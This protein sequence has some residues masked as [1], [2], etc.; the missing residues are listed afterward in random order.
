MKRS[1]N[2]FNRNTLWLVAATYIVLTTLF[3]RSEFREVFE[4]YLFDLRVSWSKDL[5][6]SDSVILVG[7]DEVT[8]SALEQSQKTP[9][10]DPGGLQLLSMES[11]ESIVRSIY[12][13]EAKAIVLLLPNHAFSHTDL[14]LLPIVN[15]IKNDPR[16]R[17]GTLEYHRPYQNVLRIP[18]PLNLVE[19][20]VFGFETFRNRS[21]IVVRDLPT[22]GFR[23]LSKKKMLPVEL[24]DALYPPKV[25]DWKTYRPYPIR[26]NRFAQISGANLLDGSMQPDQQGLSQLKD[27]I[28]I[29]GYSTNREIPFQTTEMNLVNTPHIGSQETV[30]YGI[31]LIY[32][33]ANA[34]DSLSSG[35]NILAVD[36]WWGL[37]QTIMVLLLTFGLWR[38]P[39]IVAGSLT[40]A[41]WGSVF[42]VHCLMLSEFQKV[43]P[44]ADT[45][46]ASMLGTVFFAS[47]RIRDELRQL[48]EGQ[49]IADRQLKIAK[50]QSLFL[51]QF[52][53]WL[54]NGTDSIGSD[55]TK[56][57]QPKSIEELNEEDQKVVTQF[58][59]H[60]LEASE[61]FKDYLT[62]MKQVPQID[63]IDLK[64]DVEPLQ[65]KHLVDKIQ[66]RF[67]I[68]SVEKSIMLENLIP[69]SFMLLSSPIWFDAIM[70]NL[71]SN[72]V[73]YSPTGSKVIV[74]LQVDGAN[75]AKIRV[76]DQGPGIPESEV[77]KIF[78]KFYRIQD[79]RIFQAKGTGL[80]LF[81]ARY[82]A[83]NLGGDI[84][85]EQNIPHGSVFILR[86]PI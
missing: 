78:E 10:F 70:H 24:A 45:L 62:S 73:K 32:L 41:L 69:E 46:F 39:S 65:I 34:F 44:L 66:Q 77:A 58:V 30:Q 2:P 81:L 57:N 33:F 43:I 60:A 48:A 12:L 1:S 18:Y 21:N 80:G 50:T 20:Q 22:F 67:Q 15:L 27:K 23:G 38:F 47:V 14:R 75:S 84:Q 64:K 85:I 59:E 8:I 25:D 7:I 9:S 28:V 53:Q 11:L 36:H 29:L 51:D 26:S 3:Y 55:L 71:I 42:A 6:P 17:L 82:F 86:L 76:C 52:S 19:D 49:A 56:L 5:R 63:R 83:E 79:E 37:F 74:D 16:F 72:A 13:S 40:L 31:P 68:K 61:E 4:N 35:R 54:S